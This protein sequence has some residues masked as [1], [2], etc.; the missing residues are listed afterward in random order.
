MQKRSQATRQ[1]SLQENTPK[2]VDYEN[3]NKHTPFACLK[4]K[5][6][7]EIP[8]IAISSFSEVPSLCCGI[9][10]RLNMKSI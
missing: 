10:S 2:D 5:E 9:F 7:H 8:R 6:M 1:Y 4:Y 3:T